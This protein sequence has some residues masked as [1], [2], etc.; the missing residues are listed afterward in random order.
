MTPGSGRTQN[1]YNS[2]IVYSPAYC[3]RSLCS[4]LLAPEISPPHWS[5]ATVQLAQ[6]FFK[7]AY[8]FSSSI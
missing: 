4:D 7:L 5:G 1:A 6:T 2:S 8:A 3:Q